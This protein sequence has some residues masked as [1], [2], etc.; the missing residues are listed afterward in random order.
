[1]TV[2]ITIRLPDAI[3]EFIDNKVRCGEFLSRNDFIK[4]VLRCTMEKEEMW[5]DL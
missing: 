2:D 5:I 3:V 1:M 4:H